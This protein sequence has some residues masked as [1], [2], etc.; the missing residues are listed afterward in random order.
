M[1][2][3]KGAEISRLLLLGELGRERKEIARACGLMGIITPPQIWA[4]SLTVKYARHTNHVHKTN[5]LKCIFP[6]ATRP[7]DT[8]Q[9]RTRRMEPQKA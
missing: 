4:G 9:D 6:D 2:I 8:R 1:C 3:V 5:Q 7:I